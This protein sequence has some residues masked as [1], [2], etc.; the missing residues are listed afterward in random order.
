MI[1][2][3]YPRV[4][5]ITAVTTQAPCSGLSIWSLKDKHNHD[6]PDLSAE[7][8]RFTWNQYTYQAVAV[9][10]SL[11]IVF[12]LVLSGE[13]LKGYSLDL[14]IRETHIEAILFSIVSR[15]T[16]HVPPYRIS[17]CSQRRSK[18]TKTMSNAMSEYGDWQRSWA[19]YITVCY[20]AEQW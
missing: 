13:C 3:F 16:M 19:K 9:C 8:P 1:V 6:C 2:G 14:R 18:F 7:N 11:E 17:P 10:R 4:K 15:T 20:C 5:H 12:D